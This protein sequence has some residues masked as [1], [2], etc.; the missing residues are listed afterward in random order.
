MKISV[1]TPSIRPEYLNITQKCLENQT[2]ND[3]EW[4]VEIGLRNRGFR[5]PEDL[6]KM[7]KRA[8]GDVIFHLQ[9][10]ISIENDTLERVLLNHDT[11]N[12]LI[13]YP[14]GKK[15]GDSVKWDWR[16][17]CTVKDPLQYSCWETDMSSCEKKAF[18]DVGGYDEDF[19][20]GWSWENVEI[21]ARMDIAG[22][23]VYCDPTIKGVALDHDNL[24]EN[25]FRNKI[26]N[27]DKK[28]NET[29]RRA[30]RG[31]FKLNFI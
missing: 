15:S 10:C 17:Y 4:I 2:F 3:F 18:F 25:P 20:N 28:A 21:S 14:V 23:K 7:L 27:N 8:K 16:Y 31:E 19:C 24:V 11:P 26:I 13:T 5:L 12:K 6:N 22:Y 9:D 29:R 30:E 1:I